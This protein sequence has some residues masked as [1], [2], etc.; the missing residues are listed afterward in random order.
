MEG[1]EGKLVAGRRKKRAGGY[2]RCFTRS[3]LD[4]FFSGWTL[5][6]RHRKIMKDHCCCEY[7]ELAGEVEKERDS[8]EVI[9]MGS[10][11]PE[12]T[13]TIAVD[14]GRGGQGKR[15]IPSLFFFG[16]F[17]GF[18]FGEA[19][20]LIGKTFK[21]TFLDSPP[22]FL[23]ASHTFFFAG[24]PFLTVQAGGVGSSLV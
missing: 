17:E 24:D 21:R 10:D 4:F 22:F 14:F 15:G 23:E 19:G 12:S 1:G 7:R 8:W 6:R 3:L 11:V 5:W 13:T 2:L 16:F 20:A 9:G 18:S